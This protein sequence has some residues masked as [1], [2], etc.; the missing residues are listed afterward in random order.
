VFS[1]SGSAPHLFGADLP[2]F[3]A[4]LRELLTKA[5]DNGLFAEQRREIEAVI[6]R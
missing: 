5:A 6:W 2:A 4:D 3:E 1:L